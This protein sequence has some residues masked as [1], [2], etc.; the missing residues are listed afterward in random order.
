L[1]QPIGKHLAELKERLETR[2]S[3]VNRR[4]ATGANTHFKLKGN[5]R[6]T[7]EY[8]GDDEETNHPFFDQL[9]QTDINSVLRFADRQYRFMGAFT[10][11]LG[12]S[13]KQSPDK[14][15]LIASLVGW[16]TNTGIPRMGEISD[17]SFH[18]LISMSDNF[19]R[20]ETLREANDI[21]SN[22]IARLP[23]FRHYDIGGALHSSSDGQKFETAVRTFNA[24]HSP[25]YFGL[26]KGIV[27]YTLVANNVPVNARNISADDHESHFV[28]DIIH[29]NSTD[30]QPDIHSADTHATNQANFALLH[31]F[32]DQFAPRYKDICDKV[33]TSLTAFHHPSRYDDAVLKPIRKI[34]EDLIVREWDECQRIFVSLAL[35]ETTQSTIVRKLSAQSRNGR[36]KRALWEY[37]SIHRSLYLLDYIDCPPL[38][39]HVQEAMNRG[40]NYHQL[41]RAISYA[42][43]GKLRF[44]TE[45]EQELWAEC[46]RLIANC[47]ILYNA[48]ILSRLLEHQERTGDTQGAEATKKVSPIA[49]QHI[50]L[51]GRYE[52]QKQPDPLNMDAIIRELTEMFTH[53]QAA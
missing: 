22:A 1:C 47:I 32:G 24:R 42:G 7:L 52:F 43:F 46:S 44:K 29:N 37:D 9:P 39:Q 49:W 14:A 27:S 28:F 53:G 18:T 2:L 17:I 15:A 41:R 35:K 34:R 13:A 45:Y 3:E 31:V 36:A 23:I 10:H 51:Q 25:K 5:G 16:G 11:R 19:L 40:E 6:W 21:V 26:K 38:R 50:N 4:I 48:S 33:Q 20:P 30:I 12:R 8:P